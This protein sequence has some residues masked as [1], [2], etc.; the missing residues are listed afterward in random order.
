MNIFN[1][2]NH[3]FMRCAAKTEIHLTFILFLHIFIHYSP[4]KYYEIVP[5]C[6]KGDCSHIE[7]SETKAYLQ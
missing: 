7:I 5:P 2:E 1:L 6:F 3:L 4:F